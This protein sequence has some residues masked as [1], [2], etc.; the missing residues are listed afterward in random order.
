[1]PK[2][3]W[4]T[5]SVDEQEARTRF[6]EDLKQ[7]FP[8]IYKFYI[9]GKSDLK[10]WDAASALIAMRDIDGRGEVRVVF[11]SGKIQAVYKNERV[12]SVLS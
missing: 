2:T 6:V 3:K 10:I 5:K 4:E 11:E 12:D 7:Y 9:Y 8:D 1:M